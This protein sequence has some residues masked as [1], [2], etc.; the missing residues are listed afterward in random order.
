[1]AY[2]EPKPRSI[3][4]DDDVYEALQKLPESPNK[5]LR[6]VLSADGVFDVPAVPARASITESD[7]G[8]PEQERRI[9]EHVKS[10]G[11]V[12]RYADSGKVEFRGIRPK[13]DSKR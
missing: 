3:R 2:Q 12:S 4:L 7:T 5:F 10:G 13:G 1:M 9:R 11:T 8:T 6:K